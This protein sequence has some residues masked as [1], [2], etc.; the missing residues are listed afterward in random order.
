MSTATIT[1]FPLE[2]NESTKAFERY[3]DAYHVS[4][5]IS[6]F[7]ETV[8]LG[9]IFV[10][11]VFLVAGIVAYELAR[12]WHSGFPVASLAL[13]ACAVVAVLAAH[14]WQKVFE[15]QARLLEMTVD[16]AVNSSP[17]LSNAQRA[18]AIPVQREPARVTSIEA[19]PA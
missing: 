4:Q 8:K 13:L 19:K 14:I 1:P 7:S 16:S 11:G 5:S 2:S 15:V 9:G 18:Q 6:E 3:R 10:G 17:F 12:T